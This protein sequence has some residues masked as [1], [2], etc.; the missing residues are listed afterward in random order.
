MSL[1]CKL[2]ALLCLSF[3]FQPGASCVD[4]MEA[5]LNFPEWQTI[6]SDFLNGAADQSI[7]GL[8]HDCQ[9]M[10]RGFSNI[11]IPIQ[12]SQ[13]QIRNGPES[14]DLAEH[15]GYAGAYTLIDIVMEHLQQSS[16][17]AGE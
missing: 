1:S 15:V 17:L 13:Q 6:S 5:L 7:V 10:K 11:L 14:A 12:Q 2:F 8:R 9:G 3:L 4:Q 16:T